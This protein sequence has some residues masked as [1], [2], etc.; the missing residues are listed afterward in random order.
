MAQH[1]PGA[2]GRAPGLLSLLWCLGDSGFS[3]P[4]SRSLL[5]TGICPGSGSPYATLSWSADLRCPTTSAWALG[6]GG[7]S[8]GS[9]FCVLHHV[10]PG[11][12]KTLYIFILKRSSDDVPRVMSDHSMGGCKRRAVFLVCTVVTD[13]GSAMNPDPSKMCPFGD[14]VAI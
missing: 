1:C 7:S 8:G 3:L 9:V 11:G 10:H 12:F 13:I 6:A 5:G 2:S 14:T 4:L